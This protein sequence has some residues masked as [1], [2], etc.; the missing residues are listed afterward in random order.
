MSFQDVD[1]KPSR[2]AIAGHPIHPMLVPFPI[3][4]LV[5]ALVTDLAFASTD[6]PFWAMASSWLLLAGIVTAVAAAVFGLVDFLGIP[7]VRSLN[8]AWVHFLGN[9]AAV[10]LAIWNLAQRWA[11]PVAGA[12][13]LGIALSAIVVA[14]L[15]VTGWMGGELVYRHRIGVMSAAEEERRRAQVGGVAEGAY[16]GEKPERDTPRSGL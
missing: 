2:T 12:G 15:L 10:L 7:Q 9:G 16:A 1:A 8:V 5:G 4:F 14:I 6:D 13:G 11:D 3:A